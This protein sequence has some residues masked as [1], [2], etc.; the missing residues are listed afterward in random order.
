MKERG[1]SSC[2]NGDGVVRDALILESLNSL[3][4][5]VGICIALYLKG[6]KVSWRS[7]Q[8]LI[9]PD[10]I[11]P[12][13]IISVGLDWHLVSANGESHTSRLSLFGS[14]GSTGN[15]IKRTRVECA[16]FISTCML[17]IA[18]EKRRTLSAGFTDKI[19]LITE[20]T[21]DGALLMLNLLNEVFPLTSSRL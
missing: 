10:A 16:P 13:F 19:S 14:V 21:Q 9:K 6:Y 7:L 2:P 15:N 18:T 1:N 17:I 20:N 5:I 8:A 3:Q 11:V 12:P 4:Y